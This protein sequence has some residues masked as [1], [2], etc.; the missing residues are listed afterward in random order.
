MPHLFINETSTFSPVHQERFW[1][2]GFLSCLP[3]C[4]LPSYWLA[5]HPTMHI[6]LNTRCR[7][8]RR[9][10]NKPQ[11]IVRERFYFSFSPHP[12]HICSI[13]NNERATRGHQHPV[14]SA[15]TCLKGRPSSL[16]P[17][18][19]LQFLSRIPCLL[20]K[21]K[22]LTSESQSSPF[23]SHFSIHSCVLQFS[24]ATPPLHSSPL[25]HSTS[26][27]YKNWMYL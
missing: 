26:S 25:W 9:K 20:P 12:L 27:S 1:A 19:W 18:P 6:T 22:A 3:R 14:P 2:N 17:I 10:V 24:P 11:K 5:R 23:F 4:K 13:S 15:T 8:Q 21:K 7:R 16:A